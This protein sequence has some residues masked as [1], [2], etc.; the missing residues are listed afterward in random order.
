M[1]HAVDILLVALVLCASVGYAVLA[2][3]PKSLRKRLL[4]ASAKSG[5]ACGGCDNCGTTT[6]AGIAAAGAAV[7]GPAVGGPAVGGPAVVARGEVRIPVAQI[8]R[9]DAGARGP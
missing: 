6:P 4:G 1:R 3:G 5:G 8:G 7:G 9:R 2:L